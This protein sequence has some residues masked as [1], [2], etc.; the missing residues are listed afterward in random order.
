VVFDS[1]VLDHELREQTNLP[2]IFMNYVEKL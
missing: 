1:M 2:N